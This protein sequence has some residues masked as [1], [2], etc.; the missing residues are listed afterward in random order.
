MSFY[1]NTFLFNS[2]IAKK[3]ALI[4]PGWIPPFVKSVIDK[5]LWIPRKFRKY[6]RIT[7]LLVN[8]YRRDRQFFQTVVELLMKRGRFAPRDK[9]GHVVK[10][11]DEMTD[12]EQF[13]VEE[14]KEWVVYDDENLC[15]KV[16][17]IPKVW[18]D[19]MKYYF[20]NSTEEMM[21]LQVASI[22]SR[23]LDSHFL[24]RD[25]L[26]NLK[27]NLEK[28]GYLGFV[29]KPYL[30]YLS[31][32]ERNIEINPEIAQYWNRKG[33]VCGCLE[34]MIERKAS[35]RISAGYDMAISCY[36]KAIELE[37]YYVEAWK[38]KGLAYIESYSYRKP[39][40]HERAV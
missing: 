30:N 21:K 24:H 4:P 33:I 40:G 19:P 10:N 32:L 3:D 15:Y 34:S 14:A 12:A 22:S 18:P 38:N 6:H 36:D 20:E 7:T 13:G 25:I 9:E 1:L 2:N 8:T 28:D 17:H 27:D 37:P 39:F 11:K 26:D 23:Y 5:I 35:R 16:P 29:N 31:I